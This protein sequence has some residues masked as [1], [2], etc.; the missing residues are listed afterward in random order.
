M[1]ADRSVDFGTVE[2]LAATENFLTFVRDGLIVEVNLSGN[3]NEDGK[4]SRMRFDTARFINAIPGRS[5]PNSVA[6]RV[7]APQA[8]IMSLS[9]LWLLGGN[10]LSDRAQSAT[11]KYGIYLPVNHAMESSSLRRYLNLIE[12]RNLNMVVIDMK[13]DY[14]RLR[15]TPENP[16]MLNLGRVFRPIDLDWFL[17]TMKERG[18]WTVAR[19]VVFKDPEAAR[20]QGGRYAVWDS[21]NNAPWAG[22]H[23]RR[24]RIDPDAPAP[25]PA[26]TT[27]I[28]PT[29]D[30]NYEILRTWYDERWVDPYSEIIWEY[31]TQ[32]SEELCRRGF[33]EIQWDY[34]RFPT[35]GLNLT[36]A[37]YRWRSAGMDQD[38]A[39][40]SFLRHARSRI[41]APISIDIYGANGWYRTGARTGQEVELFVPYVDIICPMYYPSHFEQF[42]LAH[43]PP[44]HRPFRIYYQGTRRTF[45]ISRGRAVIRPWAQAFFLNVSYDRQHYGPVYVQMQLDGVRA[46]GNGGITYWNNIGRY[47]EVPQ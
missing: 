21:R 3:E 20:A 29:N 42:F 15:F 18:I 13:D 19:I 37:R 44:E 5:R 36:D 22:Y 23:D 46:A 32:V 4:S 45:V 40:M 8:G 14:G 34:I 27:Q 39:I 10:R 26:L 30:P 47:D 28:L 1:W 38:S 7:S 25:N 31:N 41:Q 16:S 9:E 35:D 33:D 2:S 24:R 6:L 17:A 43:A 11:G 12:E